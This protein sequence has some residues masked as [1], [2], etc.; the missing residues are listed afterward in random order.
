MLHAVV[1]KCLAAGAAEP[2]T[3]L[4]EAL[5][6]GIVAIG[7]LLSAK[8]RSVARTSLPLL[9]GAGLSQRSRTAKDQP[10]NCDQ[11]DPVHWVPPSLSFL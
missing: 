11:N 9:R 1:L 4:L 2:I 6:N 10:G 5:L 3:V 7:H 8:P